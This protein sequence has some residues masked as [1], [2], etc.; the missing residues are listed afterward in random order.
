MGGL[1]A[2]VFT[3]GIGE[4]SS[5]IR[6]RVVEGLSIFGLQLDHNANN[7]GKRIIS[8]PSSPVTIMVLPTDEEIV[9]ARKTVEYL[10]ENQ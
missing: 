9:V 7:E 10:S 2:L 3:A 1:D 6:R 5:T 4:H 8:L